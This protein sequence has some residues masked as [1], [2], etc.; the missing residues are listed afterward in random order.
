MGRLEGKVAAITGA[1]SGIGRATAL[2]FAQ[3]GAKV[4]VIDIDDV[5]GV[6]TLSEIKRMKLEGTFIHADVSKESEIEEA[7]DS[8]VSNYG[9]L[10]IMHNNAGTVVIKEVIDCREDD[11]DKQVNI[12]LKGVFLGS[13]YAARNMITRK[14]GCIINTASIYGIVGASSYVSYCATKGGV[15]GFTKALAVELAPYNVRVN[16]VCP[17]V[18]ATPMFER[19][20]EY[21]SKREPGDV[22]KAFASQHPIGR[23]GNPNDIANAA[24]YL[25]SDEASFVTGSALVVDGGYTAV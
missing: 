11:W 4:I 16:C 22:R 17:G 19:E 23:L 8:A 21:W 5:S 10:D 24:L 15:I 1:G 14:D 2:L 18:I 7:V 6:Q 12:N 13:K 9:K 3:E 20:V 25:A